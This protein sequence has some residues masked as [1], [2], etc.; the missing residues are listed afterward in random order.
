MLPTVK[1]GDHREAGRPAVVGG[2]LMDDWITHTSKAATRGPNHLDEI[3]HA[4]YGL[5]PNRRTSGRVKS[6]AKTTN[7]SQWEHRAS[8]GY[9]LFGKLASPPRVSVRRSTCS[10]VALP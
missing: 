8:A 5:S 1:R 9:D 2:V 6:R 4:R 3:R 10:R 7:P